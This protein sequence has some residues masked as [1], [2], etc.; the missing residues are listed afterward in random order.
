MPYA[1]FFPRKASS[2]LN[3]RGQVRLGPNFPNYTF[4]RFAAATRAYQWPESFTVRF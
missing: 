4:K 1:E 2:A 3:A